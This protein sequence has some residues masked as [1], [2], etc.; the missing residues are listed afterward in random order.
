MT[1]SPTAD[2]S[3]LRTERDNAI[4]AARSILDTAK[5][6]GR[7]NLTSTEDLRFSTLN[8]EC[9]RLSDQV[10][11]AEDGLSGA[12]SQPGTSSLAAAYDQV[13]RVGQEER[14]YS[15]G[16]D[17][18][19]ALFLRDV[20]R[21]FMFRDLAADDRLRR[22][23]QE[24]RVERGQYL[25]R[26]AG[27]ANTGAFT[28]LVV[29]QYLTDMYAP[30]TAAMRPFAD[31][32]NKHHLPTSGMTVN[33]SRITTASS[34]ALQASELSAVSAT[35]M[36]DTLL[37]ENVQTAAGQ[38]TVS[39]QALERGT[40]LE[41]VVLGD[42]FRRYATTLDSTLINQATT[43]LAAVAQANA[44]TD[45]SPTAAELYPKFAAA[46]SGIETTLLGQ[47]VPSHAI[48][49]SRRWYWLQSQVGP[50]WPFMSQPGLD[51][52]VGASNFG[53]AYGS[54]TRG[55]LPNGLQAVVDNNLST[56][57]GA[58][59]NEDLIYVVPSDECHLW[60]DPQAPAFIRAEQAA[61]ANLGVLMV[62]YGYFA[63][64]MRRYG[65]GA[66]Q[67]ITGT[68]LVTPAF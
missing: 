21:Q 55:L 52:R 63:Y 30:A 40:G 14:A 57:N 64:S 28:G 16:S 59:T 41:E 3:R 39:R 38:Q 8:A 12:R 48:M 34:V 35:S 18:R 56:N 46:A 61:A 33:I 54:G 65:T 24:E 51:P 26:A 9:R 45:A 58:G 25:Q 31:V 44:Y 13:A 4:N 19:G 66:M 36:D 53:T 1:L 42:L 68:G 17:P 5:A 49:H 10:R 7:S 32:C 67:S 11:Q 47:A 29:P 20:G 6:A 27:D 62:L 37:T 22:H 60:E 23:M 15:P 50:N 43:G 2:L